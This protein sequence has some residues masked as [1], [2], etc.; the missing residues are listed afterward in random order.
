[1]TTERSVTNVY[2][3]GNWLNGGL[4]IWRTGIRENCGAGG[5]IKQEHPF[6]HNSNTPVLQFS[7]EM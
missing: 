6:L 2:V 3:K 1:M 4:E 7:E 5:F